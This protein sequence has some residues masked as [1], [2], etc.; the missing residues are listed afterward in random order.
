M[1]VHLLN[2]G[3]PDT[4]FVNAPDDSLFEDPDGVSEPSGNASPEHSGSTFADE[5]TFSSSSSSPFFFF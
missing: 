1:L 4:S 3:D 5:A 2:W